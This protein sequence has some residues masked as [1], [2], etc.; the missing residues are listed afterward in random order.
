MNRPLKL[1]LD[2]LTSERKYSPKTVD[3]YRRDVEKFFDFLL[4]EDIGMDEIDVITIRNFL[5][6][7]LNNGITK[8][9]CKRRLSALKQFYDF[10]FK[11]EFVMENEIVEGIALYQRMIDELNVIMQ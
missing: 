4:G 10:C 1:F 8:R 9:S 7:E 11:N 3:S 6:V 5:T 2:H